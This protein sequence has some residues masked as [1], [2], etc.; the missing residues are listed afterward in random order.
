MVLSSVV[1]AFY[2]IRL[3]KIICFDEPAE[4]FDRPATVDGV[5]IWGSSVVTLLFFV[6]LA[7]LIAQADA[8]AKILFPG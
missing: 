1:A 4:T 8:A 7:P 6:W 5:I 3:I 2:Y